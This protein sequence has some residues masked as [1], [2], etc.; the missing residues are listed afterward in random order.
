VKNALEIVPVSR[1]DEV[2]IHALVRQPQPIQWEE[3]LSAVRKSVPG[4]EDD[5]SGVIAH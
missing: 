3:D 1:L 2:L 4:V 5:T